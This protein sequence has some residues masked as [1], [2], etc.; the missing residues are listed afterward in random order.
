M[1]AVRVIAAVGGRPASASL[2]VRPTGQPREVARGG[3]RHVPLLVGL[4]G[5][6]LLRSKE[7]QKLERLL[8]EKAELVVFVRDDVTLQQKTDIE[9][10]LRVVP[11]V[12]GV[13][14]EDHQAAYAKLAKLYADGP[15]KMPDIEPTDVPESFVVTMRD[16]DA[17]R[18]VRDSAIQAELTAL[19]G[20]FDVVIRCTM[21][22][23]CKEN[24]RRMNTPSPAVS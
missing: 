5:C 8:D 16:Q 17:V 15:E 2:G 24:M 14:F 22:A 13:V 23:E 21:V 20:V 10:R 12:T 18:D 9:A 19:P 1:D 7:D 6:G 3:G 11:G 4:A